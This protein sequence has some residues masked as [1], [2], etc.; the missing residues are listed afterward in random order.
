MSGCQPGRVRVHGWLISLGPHTAER[1]GPWCLFLQGA[2]PLTRPP[3]SGPHC[4][5]KTFP[6][7]HIPLGLQLRNWGDSL[8]G[9][10]VWGRRNVS[11]WRAN[12]GVLCARPSRG[13]GVG[14]LHTER[15]P[16][17]SPS[18]HHCERSGPGPPAE[19]WGRGHGSLPSSCLSVR[20][21]WR[22]ASSAKAPGDSEE[23]NFPGKLAQPS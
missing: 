17:G 7:Q 3:P 10:G 20:R 11:E 13:T 21:L 5:P 22:A 14:R 4:L 1:A 19:Q 8:S 12:T 9:G 23:N 6:S 15:S 16:A 2:N 18:G